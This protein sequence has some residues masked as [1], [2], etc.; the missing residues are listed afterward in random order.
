VAGV[1]FLWTVVISNMRG[2]IE[3]AQ[4][5]AP[6]SAE[7]EQA[8]A[9]LTAAAVTP[10]AAEVSSPTS[11]SVLLAGPAAPSGQGSAAPSGSSTLLAAGGG[12][13]GGAFRASDAH[14][15][16]KALVPPG[17]ARTST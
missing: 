17:E 7:I 14:L 2:A 8:V 4:Q 16:L 5:A 11:G 1:S 3:M 13:S 15:G 9:G 12:G 6:S 10:A